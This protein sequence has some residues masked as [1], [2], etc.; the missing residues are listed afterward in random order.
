MKC[1]ELYKTWQFNTHKYRIDEEKI[2]TGDNSTFVEVQQFGDCYKEE[3]MAYNKDTKK[4]EKF[5]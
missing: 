4:C 3:C 1:P 2:I 5:K